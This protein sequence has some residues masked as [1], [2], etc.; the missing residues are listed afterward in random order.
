MAD[1]F[2]VIRDNVQKMVNAGAPPSHIN[3]YLKQ[4]GL[5]PEQFKAGLAGPQAPIPGSQEAGYLRSHPN[6]LG[7]PLPSQQALTQGRD[8]IR[9]VPNSPLDQA[10]GALG[11]Y[12]DAAMFGGADEALA[13]IESLF[14]GNFQAELSRLEQQRRDYNSVNKGQ[15][16]AAT[17][18]GL[19]L[20]PLNVVGGEMISA[21]PSVAGRTLRSAAMG[22]SIGGTAGALGTEG[23]IGDRAIGAGIGAAGGA[24][25]GGAA[26]PGLEALGFG[27]R[28]GVE[29]GRAVYNTIKNQAEAKANPGSQADKIINRALLEDKVP[30]AELQRRVANAQPGQGLVNMGGENLVGAGRQATVAKGEGRTLAQD[31]FEAQSQDAPDRAA[32]A[33]KGMSDRGYYGTVETL[34]ATRKATAK[35]LYEAAYAKPAMEVWTPRVADLLKR[36]SMKGAFA[37]AQRIAAEEGRNPK[38]L[39]LDFNEAGDPI[40]LAGADKAG[41]IPSTQ[42]MDYI[43]RGLDDV[44]E[45]YRD[46]TSGKLVLDTEGRAINNTRAEFLG[47][48]K[49]GNP[50][51]KAALD[52]YAG[53]SHALDMLEVGRDIYSS[54][55]DPADTIRRFAGL[56]QQDQDLARIGFVRD[57][58][59]DLGNVGDNGSVYLKLFGN[60]NKKAVAQVMFPDDAAFNKFAAQMQA[61]KKMLSANR[62]VQGGSPTSRIDADKAAMAGAENSIGLMDAMKSGSIVR[63][64]ASALQH[65]KNYQQGLTPEVATELAK[66]LFTSNP[67]VMQAITA[68]LGSNPVPAPAPLAALGQGWLRN[69][70]AAPLLGLGMGQAGQAIATPRR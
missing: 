33:V 15:G 70:P 67:E 22:G 30:L 48:L 39:G 42:T 53:P 12:V 31:F 1:N 9:E 21:A 5:T 28:K 3:G 58:I 17:G 69:T 4:R 25:L 2:Q 8:A 43:K 52:A 66:R 60:K 45:Q 7:G 10:H 55:G 47:I 40:F 20:N 65:G 16:Q 19:V 36:P 57:A 6:M 18:A 62:T 26:Q 32:D 61:E 37:K 41:Q 38:E 13:G 34:D 51:Y 23:G 50:D 49:E 29:G 35:P 63:M 56:S 24:I 11:N 68:R 14:G 64:F 59:A 46:K 44:V 54:R 27:A